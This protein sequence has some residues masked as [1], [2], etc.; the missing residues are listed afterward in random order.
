MIEAFVAAVL[1][2]G[3]I[4]PPP[5]TFVAL[6]QTPNY[7]NASSADVAGTLGQ[8]IAE[9]I[10]FDGPTSIVA[11]EFWGAKLDTTLED[12]FTIDF[13]T[14]AMP[15][16][17]P[18]PG[19]RIRRESLGMLPSAPETQDVAGIQVFRYIAELSRPLDVDADTTFW[20][21]IYN[22]SDGPL[23][24]NPWGWVTSGDGDSNAAFRR[25]NAGGWGPTT[26]QDYSF[27]IYAVPAPAG[28]ALGLGLILPL[29]R[30]GHRVEQ[31]AHKVC[32]R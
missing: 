14:G 6:E 18:V 27:R 30:R 8:Q 15:G 13:Y 26:G 25:G 23:T 32:K 21:A 19:A 29:A 31:F 1:M 5:G 20:M 3:T 16:G 22:N 7:A 2:T 17:S 24:G 28:V 9:N 4:E 10:R 12:D 11:V